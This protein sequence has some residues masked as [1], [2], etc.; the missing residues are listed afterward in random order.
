MGTYVFMAKCLVN[1]KGRGRKRSWPNLGGA[2]VQYN[3]EAYIKQFMNTGVTRFD[4]N[5]IH[6]FSI[7]QSLLICTYF[8]ISEV[9][10]RYVEQLIS[11]TFTRKWTRKFN[12]EFTIFQHAT[13]GSHRTNCLRKLRGAAFHFRLVRGLKQKTNKQTQWP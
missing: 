6:E 4:E 5:L 10:F 13:N 9:H 11:A 1:W 2:L 7:Q 8:S 12:S 3:F